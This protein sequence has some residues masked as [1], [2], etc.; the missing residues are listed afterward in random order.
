MPN[1]PA[2]GYAILKTSVPVRRDNLILFDQDVVIGTHC[3]HG[4]KCGLRNVR[5]KTLDQICSI[6][7]ASAVARLCQVGCLLYS[8]VMIPPALM[9]SC[10]ACS[11]TCDGVSCGYV[12]RTDFIGATARAKSAK[13]RRRSIVESRKRI[14]WQV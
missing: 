13:A 1:N 11:M 6:P 10:F 7:S 8:C 3:L 14:L 4:V 12:T 9:T 2:N 5:C